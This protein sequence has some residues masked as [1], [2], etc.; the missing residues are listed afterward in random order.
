M[1]KGN[2]ISKISHLGLFEET[3]LIVKHLVV[4]RVMIIIKNK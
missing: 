3:F 2:Y 4:G 1:Y